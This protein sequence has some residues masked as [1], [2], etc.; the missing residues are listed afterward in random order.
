MDDIYHEGAL[1][2]V[3]HLQKLFIPSNAIVRNEHGKVS[4]LR[5]RVYTTSLHKSS[6]TYER[7]EITNILRDIGSNTIKDSKQRII[8]F[9][10][11]NSPDSAAG[12]SIQTHRV[13]GLPNR[14]LCK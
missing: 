5:R 2:Q 1:I 13:W 3:P 8:L 11:R 12:K 14:P 10:D 9:N 6:K 7:D 4:N